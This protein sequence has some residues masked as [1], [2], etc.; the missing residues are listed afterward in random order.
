MTTQISP[1]LGDQSIATIDELDVAVADGAGVYLHVAG[2]A[3]LAELV[4]V[5]AQHLDTSYLSLVHA[6]IL[7]LVQRGWL[8]QNANMVSLPAGGDTRDTEEQA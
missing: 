1:P 3:Q 6:S 2:P 7:R 8:V 5:L 4:R